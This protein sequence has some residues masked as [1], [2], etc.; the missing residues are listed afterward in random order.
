MIMN[1]MYYRLKPFIPRAL[2]LALRRVRVLRRR[3]LFKHVWPI[4]ERAGKKPEGWSGWP[5]QKRFAFV[6]MHDVDTERGQRNCRELMQIDEETGFRSLFNFV[7]E[8]YAVS[9]ELRQ[10]LVRRGFEVGVHGLKH[11]G[12][13]FLSREKWPQHAMSINNY[14]KEWES[15][16]FVS[17]SMHRNLD[18]MHEVNIEYDAS[19]FDT[20]PFEPQPDGVA[21]IFPF[22]VHGNN[23]HRGYIELPYTLAQDFTLF[24]IMKEKNIDIWKKKL[25]WIAGKGGMALLIAHPDYMN[26]RNDRC[27]IEQYPADFYKEFLH[28]VKSKYDG[29]YWNPLPKEL[30]RFWKEKVVEGAAGRRQGPSDVRG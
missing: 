4:D 25:D 23:G 8:R 22:F 17:P 27:G 26:Y 5:G 2:Q 29:Q 21:T 16:G 6:L 15:V 19:T 13:L 12:K 14:L 30:A 3:E 24:I 20:D 1:R 11:D 7:P 28:Y 10:D 9:S 18:W